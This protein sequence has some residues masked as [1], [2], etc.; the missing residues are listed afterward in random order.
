MATGAKDTQGVL[1]KV[2]NG[3]SYASI[4]EVRDLAVPGPSR[5]YEDTSSL[6]SVQF[7]ES[8]PVLADPGTVTFTLNYKTHALHQQLADDFIA[9]TQRKYYV[10][11]PL[12]TPEYWGFSAT[13]SGF[14]G[15]FAQSAIQRQS[16]TLKIAGAMTRTTSEPAA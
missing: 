13:V 16:V 6:D 14:A 15:A 7:M 12:T 3:A 5:N 8:T 9:G 1:F 4:P 11:L 10:Y 2:S